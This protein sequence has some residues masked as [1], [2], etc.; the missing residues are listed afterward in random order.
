MPRKI[1]FA[2]EHSITSNMNTLIQVVI[3]YN[4]ACIGQLTGRI[5]E[6]FKRF[7]CLLTYCPF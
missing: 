3:G 4:S 1:V 7:I 5:K 2:I 6:S